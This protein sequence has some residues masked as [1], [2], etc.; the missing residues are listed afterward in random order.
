MNKRV[1]RLKE[2]SL[3]VGDDAV[4]FTP[5]RKLMASIDMM[6][7]ST[8]IPEGMSW[9]DA[10]YRAVTGATSDIAAKGGKPMAYLISLALPSQLT[11]G[12]FEE[13]WR[14]I[15]EAAELYG[16]V[17][18]GGDTNQGG[19][20][21]IDVACL[22]EAPK[23]PIPRSGAR[24]GDILA[25]TGL[26]GAQAAGL[27]ALLNRVRGEVSEEAVRRMLRPRA[28]VEEGVAL[29]GSDASASIDSSD[30]LAESLYL[31]GDASGVGFRVEEPPVDPLARRYSE[32]YGVDLFN[33]VFHGGEEYELVVTVRPEG[34]KE[35]VRAVEE[36]GGR[37]IRIGC[38]TDDV[39]VVEARWNDRWV[40]VPRKGYMHFS[41]S[42]R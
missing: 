22:A 38:A 6:V 37:L 30:G 3:P 17:I 19:Q 36:A 23:K 39:G 2:A 28:R 12:E 8:D 41:T 16:G 1:G 10:G 27:H 32:E 26:F 35:T 5:P 29:A 13:L 31:L 34:W 18:V 33:L 21:I 20:V 40:K 14:G 7:Q 9:R 42:L 25:V 4:D 24:P 11:R 15:E